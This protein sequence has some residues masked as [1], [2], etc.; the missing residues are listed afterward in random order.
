LNGCLTALGLTHHPHNLRE[1]G[2][3]PNLGSLDGEGSALVD[4]TG[5][6]FVAGFF[7]YRQG[8]ATDH[9]FIDVRKS[10]IDNA[11]HRYA[12]SGP[13]HYQVAYL[14]L[15]NRNFLLNQRQRYIQCRIWGH[16]SSSEA[17]G[18]RSSSRR[19]SRSSRGCSRGNRGGAGSG[20]GGVGACEDA[21]GFRLEAHK[22][23]DGRAGGVFCALF[24]KFAQKHKRQDH[25]G[26][27]V[28][29][30]NLNASAFQNAGE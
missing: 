27:L 6:D 7:F 5:K 24:Q 3:A 9:T 10:L 18:S 28:V 11:I 16:S 13:H 4:G 20:G 22:T 1:D 19:W 8:L 30:V 25:A 2:P 29:D 26:G 15:S 21:C 17:G 12:F 23:A 14:Q